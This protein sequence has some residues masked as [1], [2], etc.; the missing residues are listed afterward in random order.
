M[1]LLGQIDTDYTTTPWYVTWFEQYSEIH[2]QSAPEDSDNHVL[3]IHYKHSGNCPA[4]SQP[5]SIAKCDPSIC[6]GLREAMSNAKLIVNAVNEKTGCDEL[7]I[8]KALFREIG[9]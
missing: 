5:S 7:L 4:T 8:N 2:I 1:T 6:E 3:S 9:I